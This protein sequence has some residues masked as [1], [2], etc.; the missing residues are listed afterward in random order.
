M[1]WEK[2]EVKWYD[3]R[4]RAKRHWIELSDEQLDRIRGNRELLVDSLQE[5]YG[6]PRDIADEQIRDWCTTFGEDDA[7][8]SPR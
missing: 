3:Y 5:S 4:V 1:R 2:I 6:L 7:H 8:L